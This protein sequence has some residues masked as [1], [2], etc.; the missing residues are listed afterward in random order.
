MGVIDLSVDACNGVLYCSGCCKNIARFGAVVPTPAM[1]SV[2][3]SFVVAWAK[4]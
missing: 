3:L 2:G 1:A 4:M